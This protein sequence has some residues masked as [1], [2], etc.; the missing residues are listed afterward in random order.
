MQRG[1]LALQY[2][3]IYHRSGE[4]TSDSLPQVG[5]QPAISF[6]F[7]YFWETIK[8]LLT[9]IKFDISYF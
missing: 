3:I 1:D 5:V 7:A 2:L 4:D 6:A 9:K 8:N